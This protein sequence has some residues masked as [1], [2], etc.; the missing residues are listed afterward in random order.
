MLEL[1]NPVPTQVA[2]KP[3]CLIVVLNQ[4]GYD[5]GHSNAIISRTILFYCQLKYGNY[6]L[7]TKNAFSIDQL[8]SQTI[9]FVIKNGTIK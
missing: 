7:L 5:F 2:S 3:K 6:Q 8:L 9:C 1:Y 4:G